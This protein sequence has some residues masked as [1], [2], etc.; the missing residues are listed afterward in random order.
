MREIY[1]IFDLHYDKATQ[2]EISQSKTEI[3]QRGAHRL[4]PAA[5]PHAYTVRGMGQ[6]LVSETAHF[7][8][9]DSNRAITSPGLANHLSPPAPH[10]L[11]RHSR[12]RTHGGRVDAHESTFLGLDGQ[13]VSVQPWCL[14]KR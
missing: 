7:K 8:S 10:D 9:R 12:S 6:R 2:T 13:V 1:N 4:R 5:A 3:S 14:Y 11:E